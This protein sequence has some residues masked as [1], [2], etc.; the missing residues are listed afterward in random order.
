[1]KKDN[2]YILNFELQKDANRYRWLRTQY[3]LGKETYLAEN[4][5]SKKQLDSYIDKKL[6]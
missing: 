3:A 1:M 4:I 5:K 6:E 2:K